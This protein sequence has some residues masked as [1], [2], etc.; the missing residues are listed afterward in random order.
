MKRY[1]TIIYII[2]I[3]R[4]N[5]NITYYIKLISRWPRQYKRIQDN[6]IFISYLRRN[7]LAN[8]QCCYYHFITHYKSCDF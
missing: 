1:S 7:Q 4:V 5:N 2:Y 6:T 3:I 8:A